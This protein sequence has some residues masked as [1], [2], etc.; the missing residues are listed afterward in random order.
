MIAGVPYKIVG[1]TNFYAR[2]EIKDLLCYLKTIDNARDD[3]AVR[4]VINVPKRG[5]GATTLAKV[6]AYAS[7]E[8]ISFYQA[9]KQ[10]EDITSLGRS[11]GKIRPFV[12]LIQTMRS[13]QPHL[14]VVELLKEVIEETGY[15]QE[16]QAED[17]VESISRIENIDE[18]IS[19]AAAYEEKAKL[20]EMKPSL[21]GFLEEVALVAE[22]DKLETDSDYVVLMTLHS[23]KGLEFPNVYLAGLEDGIFP[24]YMTI[25]SEDPM[26]IEEERRL[27]YVGITRAM[28]RLT[29]SAAAV[30]MV[31]GQIQRNRPS[32]FLKEIPEELLCGGKVSGR[33][34]GAGNLREGN[35][36]ERKLSSQEIGT[37]LF[38]T[39]DGGNR[40]I[41]EIGRGSFGNNGGGKSFSRPVSYGTTTPQTGGLSYGVGDKVKHLKFG[42]GVVTNIV[43]GGKDFE[44]TVEFDE[45]G[46]KKMFAVFAKLEKVE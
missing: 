2:K 6:Q 19:K 45:L 22:I 34:F 24:S 8:D 44:V 46:T 11:A 25:T 4:R 41:Q 9:L 40:Q 14:G 16:L 39:G 17:S 18:L 42:A 12:N 27:C 23:A 3:L 10:A 7:E 30:R 26:E 43:A 33:G 28:K 1:G 37:G 5:I 35:L 36:S 21:S 13:K 38:G 20:Q 31:R 32:R 15:V 29:L